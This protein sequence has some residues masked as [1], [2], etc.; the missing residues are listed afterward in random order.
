MNKQLA[1][2]SMPCAECRDR[3]AALQLMAQQEADP[4]AG[5]IVQEV[6]LEELQAF[7]KEHL[8]P[9][10]VPRSA[11]FVDEIPRNAMGKVNKKQLIKD[12]FPGD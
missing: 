5:P 12:L 6:T 2:P 1:R 11:I 4:S 7:S 8:P 10:Q 3:P 9:Y